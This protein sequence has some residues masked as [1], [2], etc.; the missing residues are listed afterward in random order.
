[1]TE[2]KITY[3]LK[4]IST[5]KENKSLVE[6]LLRSYHLNADLFRFILAS[7]RPGA[8][9]GEKK[10]KVLVNELLADMDKD[11]GIRMIINKRSLKALKTWL[12]KMDVFFKTL[13]LRFPANVTALQEE[14]EKIYGLLK[15]SANKLLVSR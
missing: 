5:C 14:T 11:P 2:K 4:R 6:A 12:L 10:M 3:A 8:P 1:M 7:V 13:K 15:I 9:A